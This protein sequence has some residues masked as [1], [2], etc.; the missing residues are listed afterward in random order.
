M[1]GRRRD[2]RVALESIVRQPAL[3]IGLVL[4]LVLVL[5]LAPAPAPALVP[6]WWYR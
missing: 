5:V 3:A 4:V 2:R 1:R 6:T